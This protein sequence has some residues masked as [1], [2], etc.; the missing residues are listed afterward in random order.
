M[1]GRQREILVMHGSSNRDELGAAG[2]RT[3]TRDGP[4]ELEPLA[5]TFENL[6][7]ASGT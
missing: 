4:E 7:R 1:P 2:Q 6:W 3:L 5:P